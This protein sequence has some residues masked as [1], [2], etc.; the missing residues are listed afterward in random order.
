MS[1]NI[2]KISTISDDIDLTSA[3]MPPVYIYKSLT[4]KCEEIMIEGLPLGGLK[5]EKFAIN[6]LEFSKGDVLVMM[7]DGLAEAANENDEMFDYPRIKSL[8]EENCMKSP[9]EIKNVFFEDLNEWL[10]GGIPEDDVTLVIVKK[11]A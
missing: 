10:K 1:L 11:V 2:A 7:S 4:N 6:T 5:N 9:E 3:A 8:I